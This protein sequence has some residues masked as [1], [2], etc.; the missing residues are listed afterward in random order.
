MTIDEKR[1]LNYLEKHCRNRHFTEE[2]IEI[3]FRNDLTRDQV[4]T[5]ILK[6]YR[7]HYIAEPYGDGK[8]ELTKTKLQRLIPKITRAIKNFWLTFT[9]GIGNIIHKS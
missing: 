6:L 3:A 7:Y 2:E 5:I 4:I 1:V 9:K 8:L